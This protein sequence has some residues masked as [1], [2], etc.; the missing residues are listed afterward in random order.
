MFDV[1]IVKKKSVLLC[2]YSATLNWSSMMRRGMIITS[3]VS[4]PCLINCIKRSMSKINTLS[5]LKV[6]ICIMGI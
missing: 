1:L 6:R 5:N 3:T 4:L 2:L